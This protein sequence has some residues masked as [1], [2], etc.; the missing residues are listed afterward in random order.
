MD[1]QMKK[2][3]TVALG[4]ML[5]VGLSGLVVAGSLDSPGAPSAGS[6]MYTLQNLYDYLTSGAALTVQSSFQEPTSGP[7]VGTMKTTRQI[8]DDIA[9]LFGQCP[10]TASN[11][12]SGVK[13][14]CALPGSWGVQTGTAQLMPT[15][16]RTATPTPPNYFGSGSDGDV[17]ISSNT[18]LAVLNKNGAYDGD[19]V[20]M[21]YNSLTINSGATL[22]TEQ[23]CR[24]LLVYVKENCTINGGLSMTARGAKANPAVAGASDNAAVSSTGIRLPV[25]KSGE[26][27]TLAAVDFAGCGNAAVN[28][29]ANQSG[30]SGNGKIFII[31]RAGAS[32]APARIPPTNENGY[33]GSNGGVGQSGGGGS[34]GNG[35]NQQTTVGSGSAGTCF[36]GGSGSGGKRETSTPVANAE[37][38]G[39]AGSD[40][41]WNGTHA[42]GGGSGN[43]GGA[44][45]GGGPSGG[46][47]TGGLLILVVGGNLTMGSSA[48]ISSD[49]TASPDEAGCANGGGSGGGNILILH[50]GSYTPGGTIQCKGGGPSISAFGSGGKGGDGSIILSS[51]APVN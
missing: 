39:G 25:F 17:T 28:A 46:N 34:G 47:G 29:A 15:P 44:G 31:N 50:A 38:Y 13:F 4:F 43:P 27:D 5:M 37:E 8:G 51:I 11:V 32:G 16:T 41:Q 18:Q 24:G 10:A 21:N 36:S 14:F 9:A 30:I 48:L 20:V 33:S 45:K 42:A 35:G 19:M 2:L 7:T 3:I 1:T 26:V 6:G 49:G 22:T 12:E 40:G 23:P